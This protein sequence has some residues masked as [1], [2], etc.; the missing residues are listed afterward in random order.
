MVSQSMRKRELREEKEWD[1]RVRA[2]GI[3]SPDGA[4]AAATDEDI[5]ANTGEAA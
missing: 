4:N 5:L 2:R 3:G 1:A